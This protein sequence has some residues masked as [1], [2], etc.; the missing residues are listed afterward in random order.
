MLFNNESPL[1]DEWAK[2][3]QNALFDLTKH[4]KEVFGRKVSVKWQGAQLLNQYQNGGQINYLRSG[5]PV[6]YTIFQN[7]SHQNSNGINLH[8]FNILTLFINLYKTKLQMI[9]L[10]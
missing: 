8:D 6:R 2:Q 1:P 10:F 4:R 9:K 7:Q 3:L 5:C